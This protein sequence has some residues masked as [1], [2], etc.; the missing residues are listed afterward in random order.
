MTVTTA[1]GVPQMV[2]IGEALGRTPEAELD[3]WQVPTG[4]RI[5]STDSHWLEGDIWVDR[6]PPHLRDR[7]PRVYFAEGGWQIDVDGKRVT[8]PKAAAASCLFECVTGFSDVETRMADLDAEGVDAELLFPQKFFHLMFLKDLEQ[9]EWCLRGYNQHLSEVCAQQPERL[10]GVGLLK[11]WDPEGARDWLAEAKDLG[12]RT[13]MI[14]MVPGKYADGEPV[15]YTDERMDPMWDAIEESGMPLCFHIGERFGTNLGRGGTGTEIM[16][17]M[18][19]MRNQWSSV[20]FSGLFDRNPTLQV[21]FVESGLHWVPGALQEADMI[22]ESFPTYMKPRLAHP[23]SWYWHNNCHA[24]FMVDPA[25]LAMIDRIGADRVMW[26]SDYPHNESTLGYTRSAVRA[27][28]E[29]T[30]ED[31]A[32]AIVGGNANRLFGI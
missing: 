10:H 14:P 4:T 5:V 29:S 30:T 31:Q 15:I 12:F 22:Y 9:R 7:A 24:T 32:K 16:R 13:V 3:D 8:D 23:P 25:G 2:G 1:V 18:G 11:W 19:G 27:V 26:S 21:A 20:V 17:Q 28:F 6:F